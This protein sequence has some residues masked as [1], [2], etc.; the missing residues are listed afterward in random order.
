MLPV[1]PKTFY[2]TPDLAWQHVLETVLP[3]SVQ[4]DMNNKDNFFN[5]H[6][7]ASY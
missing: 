3:S 4:S 5:S 6:N 1:F 2:H 7:Y